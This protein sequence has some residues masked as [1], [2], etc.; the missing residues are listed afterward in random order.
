ML[1]AEMKKSVYNALV[2]PHLDYCSVVWQECTKE[3]QQK[4]QWV[5]N[6]GMRLTLSKPP[7]T[8]SAEPREALGWIPSTER[9]RLFRLAVVHRCVNR[10]GP[11][12]MKDIIVSNEV[13]GCRRIRGFKKLHLFCINTDLYRRSFTFRGSQVPPR[14]HQKYS[15]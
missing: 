15:V 10:Q 5:Q 14:G 8:P 13:A 7:Q 12:L 4:V 2:L 1:P 6:H 9:R 3:L 11:E